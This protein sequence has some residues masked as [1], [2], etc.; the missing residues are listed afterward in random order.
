MFEGKAKPLSVEGVD[1]ARL[2][3]MVDLPALWA[4]MTVETKGCGFLADRRPVILFERHIFHRRTN[5]RFDA[6]APDLSNAKPGG[7]GPGGAAQYERLIRAIDLDRTAALESTSWGLGQIMGFNSVAAGFADVEAMVAAMS[8]SE[9]A[10][11]HGMAFFIRNEGIAEYLKIK[12]WKSFAYHY[13]G[14][15]FQKNKY[16][17]NLAHAYARF[18]MGPLPDLRI[19]AAQLYLTVLGFNPHGVDGWFGVNTQKALVRF[20][21]EH[22]LVATGLLDEKSFSML[23][24]LTIT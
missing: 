21:Q 3:L 1:D 18:I 11:L 5:G 14:R 2:T 7:Y 15:N 13:N 9:D 16:D 8:Q 24:E 22:N 12:D 17:T 10:Q 4:V 20:Q 23:E 6:V 19:R